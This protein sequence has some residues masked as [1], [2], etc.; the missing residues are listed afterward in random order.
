MRLKGLNKVV[1]QEMNLTT[2]LKKELTPERAT[3]VFSN[4]RHRQ[5]TVSPE[6]WFSLMRLV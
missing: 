5:A 3:A 1:R 6:G 4:H 2:N